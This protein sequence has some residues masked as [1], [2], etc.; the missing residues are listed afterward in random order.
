MQ[1]NSRRQLGNY[2]SESNEQTQFSKS[3]KL[4]K[5]KMYSFALT[6]KMEKRITGQHLT[7]LTLLV[8]NSIL[9]D[10]YTGKGLEV[11]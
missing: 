11:H 10:P 2:F 9:M 8:K 4:E 7:N 6:N 1:C 3:Y 5:L